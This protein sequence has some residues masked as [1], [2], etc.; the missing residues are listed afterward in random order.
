MGYEIRDSN[1]Y[2]TGES[3]LTAGQ[4]L[5]AEVP[6]KSSALDEASGFL[7]EELRNGPLEAIKVF[8]DARDNGISVI[9]LKRAK[10]KLKIVSRREGAAGKKGAGIFVWEL[11]GK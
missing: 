4:I 1:F 9:T 3:Q 8:K 11:P 6:D 2:W 10:A 7:K 5:S